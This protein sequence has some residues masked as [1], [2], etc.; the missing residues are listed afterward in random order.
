L[1]LYASNHPDVPGMRGIHLFHFVMSNCSQRVRIALEEKRLEWTSHHVNMMG[2]EHLTRDYQRINPNGVVPTLVHD[3][4]VVLESND[5][6]RYLDEHFPEPA[7]TPKGGA[8]REAME[9]LIDLASDFQPTS[10]T[11]SHE[12]LFRAFRKVSAE[13]VERFEKEH[14]D[15]SLAAFLKDYAEEG[16]AWHQRVELAK[17]ERVRVFERLESTLEGQKWFTRD[18]Y[19]MAD[20]SWVVNVHRLQQAKVDITPWPRLGEWVDRTASRPA[21]ERAVTSYTP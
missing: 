14:N 15:P 2:H 6:L 20:V 16:D 18:A 9:T 19:G 12:L 4:Q 3:G 10:K 13:E 1:G 7:L 5:I 21:F 11:L 17:S 8:S